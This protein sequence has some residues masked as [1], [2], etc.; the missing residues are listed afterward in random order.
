MPSPLAHSAAAFGI[1][2]VFR[3]YDSSGRSLFRIPLF[4]F[5]LLFFSLLPD[6][7]AVLGVLSGNMYAYHNQASNSVFTALAAS[8]FAGFIAFFF[9]KKKFQKWFFL[10]LLCYLMHIAMDFFTYGRGLMLFWPLTSRRFFPPFIIFYGL[11]WSKSVT[12]VAHLYTLLNETAV[13]LFV[14]MIWA[15]IRFIRLRKPSSA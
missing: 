11:R 9:F 15:L 4:F 12:S 2:K 10:C 8:L 13:I 14:S 6:I 3:R 5:W 1:Y 7:D